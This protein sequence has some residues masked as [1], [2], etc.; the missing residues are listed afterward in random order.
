MT[1]L[2]PTGMRAGHEIAPE[3]PCWTARQIARA[4]AGTVALHQVHGHITWQGTR[5]YWQINAGPT[6]R[7]RT[8]NRTPHRLNRHPVLGLVQQGQRAVGRVAPYLGDDRLARQRSA[9]RCT[10]PMRQ[11]SRAN[12]VHQPKIA[13]SKFHRD[14]A[15]RATLDPGIGDIGVRPYRFYG[16]DNQ[17]GRAERPRE[18]V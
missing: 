12:H 10:V 4:A 15:V 3:L 6:V 7:G 17:Q 8:F 14:L 18:E 9:K 5:A 2:R 11:L 1:A 16:H 13:Q